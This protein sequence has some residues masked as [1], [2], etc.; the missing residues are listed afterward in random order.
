LPEHDPEKHAHRP[1]PGDGYRFSDQI[2]LKQSYE[3]MIRFDR[4]MAWRGYFAKT[5]QAGVEAGVPA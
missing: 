3:A 5:R 4:I 2:M 1:W